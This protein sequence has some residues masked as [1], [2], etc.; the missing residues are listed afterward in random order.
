MAGLAAAVL[1]MRLNF[2]L[3][4]AS[5]RSAPSCQSG[6]SMMAQEGNMKD[7]GV[8]ARGTDRTM[9]F[10]AACGRPR[11]WLAGT[12]TSISF[13]FGRFRLPMMAMNS[14]S[15]LCASRGLQRRSMPIVDE[16]NPV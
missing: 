5:V 10:Q 7:V 1:K 2:K 9:D 8:A 14:A 11:F 16:V 6:N 13:G 15:D 12:A 4:I 3:F